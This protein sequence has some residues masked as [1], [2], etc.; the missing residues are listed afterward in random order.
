MGYPRSLVGVT[1]LNLFS[2]YKLDKATIT[3]DLSKERPQWILSAYGPGRDAPLQLFG[4]H[5]REQSFEELRVRHYELVAQGN[6]QQAIQEAQELVN[7]AE[8]Q[9]QT[10]LNDV[11]GAVNYIVN[12]ENEHPNRLDMCR[13]KGATPTQPQTSAPNQQIT[14]TFGQLSSLAP[15]FGQPSTTSAFDRPS[16]PS[17]GQPSV[18][19]STFGQ[20]SAPTFGQPSQPSAF[21]QPSSLGRQTTSFGQPS[22]TFG[23]PSIPAPTFG[24]PSAPSSLGAPQQQNNAFGKPSGPGLLQ[25]PAAAAKNPFGQPLAPTPAPTFGQP[26]APSQQSAFGRPSTL[27][28]S[29]AFGQSATSGAISGF[30]QTSTAPPNPFGQPTAPSTTGSFGQPLTAA[31]NP[32]GQRTSTANQP[33]PF[34]Q[35]S[36]TSNT[37]QPPTLPVPNRANVRSTSGQGTNGI[38]VQKDSQGKITTWEGFSVRYFDDEPCYK[39]NDGSWQR[40]WF[41]DGPPVFT[42]SVELP[43]EAYDEATKANYRHLKE[44]GTFQDGIMPA[45]PPR[46]EWCSWNF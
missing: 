12:G 18:P 6:Q 2:R 14:S 33:F 42:K 5:P 24:Q 7:N 39:S 20:P 36:G 44:T 35:T 10:A 27:N 40:I 9:I 4:G 21:G 13:A 31:P 34:V 23:R 17:F 28:P 29:P 11:D 1:L 30:S 16:V 38:Q 43:V 25:Q 37:L 41:P 3:N 32:F 19:T 46:R 15:T 45:L 22:S 8:Q 26:S